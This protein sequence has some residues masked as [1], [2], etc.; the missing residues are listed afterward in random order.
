MAKAKQQ[1]KQQTTFEVGARVF[2]SNGATGG[3]NL[4]GTVIEASK[5]WYNIQLDDPEANDGKAVISA[6]AGSMLSMDAAPARP[7]APARV[8][9][10]DDGGEEGDDEASGG[11]PDE[12]EAMTVA[13]RMAEALKNARKRYTKT[14]RPNGASSA[15]CGDKTSRAMQD[16]EPIEAAYLADK[17]LK[18]PDGTHIGKYGHLNPGQIRMNSGNRIRAAVKAAIEKDDSEELVR[19]YRL[20]GILDPEETLEDLK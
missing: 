14:K 12:D 11:E 16:L 1:T 17:V 2:V 9:E 15:C 18:Q 20:L 7:T 19:I 3:A 8:T 6:R 5:G 4:T 13:Q 10:P